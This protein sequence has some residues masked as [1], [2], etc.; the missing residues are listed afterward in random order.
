MA[1]FIACIRRNYE[2]FPES[3]F[4]PEL[5]EAEAERARTLYRD[6]VFRQ[7]W[8]RG[9]APGAVILIEAGSAEEAR[10]IL[11]TL[12]LKERQMLLVDEVIPLTPYRGFGPRG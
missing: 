9:D 2:D 12:P 1:Q 3:D 6:G 10:A 7:T 5:L 11:E 4:T 8:G